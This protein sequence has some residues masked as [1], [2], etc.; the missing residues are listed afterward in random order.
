LQAHDRGAFLAEGAFMANV[1]ICTIGG[2]PAVVTE[3][4]WCLLKQRQPAWRPD[5]IEIVTTGNPDFL[6][7]SREALQNP[8]GPLAE[9]LGDP[10]VPVTIHVPCAEGGQLSFADVDALGVFPGA[11]T[12]SDMIV[13]I[14]NE[15]DALN[16]ADCIFNC[17]RRAASETQTQI[18]LS[19]AG[20]RKTMSAHA[21]TA[22]GMLARI[23]DEASHVLV[24]SRFENVPGFWHPDQQSMVKVI[25][26]T[27]DGETEIELDPKEATLD[28][29]PSDVPL[30]RYYLNTGD[31]DI[32]A[33]FSFKQAVQA[34]NLAKRLAIAP[35]IVLD[36]RTNFATFCG[37]QVQLTPNQFAI[38][39]LVCVAY[40]DQWP[41]AGP[42]EPKEAAAHVCGW[43]T[44]DA[45]LNQKLSDGREIKHHFADYLVEADACSQNFPQ[46]N[47]REDFLKKHA[48][49]ATDISGFLGSRRTRL[50]ENLAGQLGKEA[51]NLIGIHSKSSAKGKY[52]K[53]GRFGLSPKLPP[54]CIE[55]K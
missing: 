12:A 48:Q 5:R 30:M 33:K 4:V 9:L 43:L 49:E 18:H 24:D 19:L 1:L 21:L 7:K 26:R 55:I 31:K 35:H 20:G 3:T 28:L 45:I 37:K 10:A 47:M 13:D 53:T 40:K 16:M 41:G 11:N 25:R 17:L 27:K 22:F 8:R 2:S 44:H 46:V 38:Y 36:T 15:R 52:A 32:F 51:A 29:V 34:I 14:T 39:R 42:E 54:S 23:C 50:M 6:D